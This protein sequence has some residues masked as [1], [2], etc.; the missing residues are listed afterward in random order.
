MAGGQP[1]SKLQILL[2][3]VLTALSVAALAAC[4]YAIFFNG[5]LGAA[6]LAGVILLAMAQL[7]SLFTRA[8]LKRDAVVNIKDLMTANDTLSREQ[9]MLRRRLDRVETALS[10]GNSAASIQLETQVSALEHSV[11]ALA[12]QNINSTPEAAAR[13]EPAFD[14]S[15]PPGELDL[16]L[17]PIIRLAENRTAYYRATLA[18]R[19][20]ENDR[21]PVSRIARE[22]ERAGFLGDL[23]LTVF[24][25][26][27]P[28]I[29]RLQNK[30]RN[31]AVFCPV[32]GSSFADEEFMQSLL[33]LLNTNHDIASALI[34]EITH[35]TL[36]KLSDAG[37]GGLA[38]LAQL[39]ATFALSDIRDN[40]PDLVT[41]QELGFAFISADVRFLVAVKNEGHQFSDTILDQV[42]RSNL[43]MIAANVVKESEF[44]WIEDTVPLAYGTYF[45]PPRLVRH[46]ITET[47]E[48]AKVA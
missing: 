31:V 44:A 34:I 23:D 4:A 19:K 36:S 9:L 32:N 30:G 47:Q 22:A 3:I 21:L 24:E 46:D 6:L 27:A 13:V 18:I 39:G 40:I 35:S 26:A 12:K 29:R 48:H 15:V 5:Q 1:M 17:E 7:L 10:S 20:G 14:A 37:Q 2:A 25:M 8:G 42:A 33:N 41:L 28:V 11:A 38:H 43:E 45:S 16:F